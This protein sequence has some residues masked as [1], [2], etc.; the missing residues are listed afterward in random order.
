[1]SNNETDFSGIGEIVDVLQKHKWVIQKLVVDMH[2]EGHRLEV[3][4]FSRF[5]EETIKKEEAKKRLRQFG[6]DANSLRSKSYGQNNNE[7]VKDTVS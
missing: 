7:K 4:A 3:V 6:K 1:M 2:V 5:D